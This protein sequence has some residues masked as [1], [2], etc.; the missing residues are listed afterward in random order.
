M[1][2]RERERERERPTTQ[3]TEVGQLGRVQNE[4]TKCAPSTNFKYTTSIRLPQHKHKCLSNHSIHL[5]SVRWTVT[6]RD[7]VHIDTGAW[8]CSLLECAL[9]PNTLN[10][11]YL[12]ESSS[13]MGQWV[14][15][16]CK[17][18]PPPHSPRQIIDHEW[19]KDV[20]YVGWLNYLLCTTLIETSP[21]S[22]V[23]VIYSKTNRTDFKCIPVY[24]RV[25]TWCPI[26][27]TFE[28]VLCW[29][30]KYQSTLSDQCLPTSP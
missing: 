21:T 3:P 6:T 4:D 25:C 28:A 12:T 19:V 7:N 26:S 13:G 14:T 27:T 9:W 5:L 20:I 22:H 2:V 29:S 15:E 18:P 17:C 10:V 23:V 11:R 1:C 30:L 16:R 24:S 8:Q